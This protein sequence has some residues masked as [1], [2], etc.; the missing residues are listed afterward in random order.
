MSWL[1]GRSRKGGVLDRFVRFV[2]VDLQTDCWMWQGSLNNKGYGYFA[3][4]PGRP[5]SAHVAAIKIF[6]GEDVPR[7]M[8]A[9]HECDTP[10]CANP[11]HIKVI[12]FQEN[13]QR[14]MR[15]GR[16]KRQFRRRS[17]SHDVV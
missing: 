17:N 16:G 9:G 10:S 6:R 12:T 14:M 7:G 4:M 8:V 15:L 3:Y 11:A 2:H 1:T 5:L 13:S